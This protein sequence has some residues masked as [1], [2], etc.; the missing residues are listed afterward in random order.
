MKRVVVDKNTALTALAA[1]T[2][3]REARA[4]SSELCGR[5]APSR[6][7]GS[8]RLYGCWS[9]S[10]FLFSGLLLAVWFG[11]TMEL[12]RAIDDVGWRRRCASHG[13]IDNRSENLQH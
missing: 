3:A 9:T 5:A 7:T 10:P 12:S 1:L 11:A 6:P 8:S 4:D 2:R 13:V